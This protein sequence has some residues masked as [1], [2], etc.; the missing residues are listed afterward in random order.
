MSDTHGVN[1]EG[2]IGF[3]LDGTLAKYDGWQGLD[4]IG[5]PIEAMVRLAKK[6]H[7]EGKHIKILTARV[8]PRQNED[9]VFGEQGII[10]KNEY[11]VDQH[12]VA[13]YFIRKWCEANLGFVPEIVHQKDHL[14]L[15]LYDDRVKQVVPN[16][17]VLVEDLA[18]YYEALVETH[19]HGRP[20]FTDEWQHYTDNEIKDQAHKFLIEAGLSEDRID[21]LVNALGYMQ[22]PA[23]IHHHLNYPGGLARHSVNVTHWMLRLTDPF[24]CK[25]MKP[26]SPYRIGMLHDLVKCYCYRP[27]EQEPGK[28]RWM[29]PPFEGHGTTSVIA[30]VTELGIDLTTQEA[31]CIA[32]HMGAFGLDKDELKQYDAVIKLH[33]REILLTHT[34]DM[35]AAKVTEGRGV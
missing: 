32:W 25:W 4:H 21:F 1:G 2:W 33:P 27:D 34:A 10:L 3:D 23:S 11:G 29:P 19:R 35:L 22:T 26:K 13:S 7:A 8:A 20:I 15:E 9:G 17:G 28:Y 24:E 5:E 12:Y 6:F 31:L 16:K 18:N 14:M 30:A